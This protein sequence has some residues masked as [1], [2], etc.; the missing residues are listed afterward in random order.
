MLL[1]QPRFFG[2][3]F[4]YR[5]ALFALTKY[6]R[7]SWKGR[8]ELFQTI[9]LGF[10]GSGTTV[11]WDQGGREAGTEVKYGL[12]LHPSDLLLQRGPASDTFPGTSRNS[13]TCQRPCSAYVCG[14]ITRLTLGRSEHMSID[15]RQA[16]DDRPKEAFHTSLAQGTVG[17][18]GVPCRAWLTHRQ[19]C[20]QNLHPSMN[21]DPHKPHPWAPHT[22]FR[23]FCFLSSSCCC[24][25]YYL[26]EVALV[27]CES[28]VD[29]LS[30]MRLPFP[31]GET[32]SGSGEI[33]THSSRKYFITIMLITRHSKRQNYGGSDFV[34]IYIC[35]HP[36]QKE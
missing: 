28:H 18:T 33:V 16:T 23:E 25:S 34:S 31:T 30:L 6:P 22:P 10:T 35:Q 19:L 9:V 36:Q 14:G 4:L 32:S 29:F 3:D 24:Q 1:Q 2:T 21:G 20:Q 26:G 5:L 7:E 11:R 13:A 27:S 12:R 8:K 17:F 15:L